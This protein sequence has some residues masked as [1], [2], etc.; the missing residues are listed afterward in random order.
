MTKECYQ[1]KVSRSFRISKRYNKFKALAILTMGVAGSLCNVNSSHAV[2]S[3]KEIDV[4]VV[5][6]NSDPITYG[7]PT[8]VPGSEVSMIVKLTKSG[9][10]NIFTNE[11]SGTIV[12]NYAASG[13]QQVDLFGISSF[14][15]TAPYTYNSQDIIITNKA[16]IDLTATGT[17]MLTGHNSN[18]TANVAGIYGTVDTN[19]GEIDVTASGGYFGPISPIVASGSANAFAKGIYGN[20]EKNSG[21]ITASAT[22]GYVRAVGIAEAYST[23]RGIYG[24]V[25]VNEGNIQ[26]FAKG[27]TAT[28]TASNTGAFSSAN[29][30]GILGKVVRNTGNINVIVEGGVARTPAG[31]RSA[32]VSNAFAYGVK[33]SVGE[34][35]GAIVVSAQGGSS[36]ITESGPT[37]IIAK[38][39]S[40]GLHN[41]TIRTDALTNSGLINVTATG[42]KIST[43][44]GGSWRGDSAKSYGIYDSGNIVNSKTGYIKTIAQ[45]ALELTDDRVDAEIKSYGVYFHD[46]GILDSA[47]LIDAE[48]RDPFGNRIS[49]NNFTSDIHAYQVYAASGATTI[50]GFAMD[51]QG[52]QAELNTK[53]EGAISA[54]SGATVQFG[55]NAK[56]YVYVN[57]E[58][59]V[60]GNTYTIPILIDGD[61]P[62]GYFSTAEEV[63]INPDYRL[64]EMSEKSDTALQT[65]TFEYSPQASTPLFSAQGINTMTQQSRAIVNAATSNTIIRSM[66]KNDPRLA[67]YDGVA[68]ASNDQLTD[69]NAV[70]EA[71]RVE[72]KGT[73]FFQP[74]YVNSSYDSSPM[75]Y[76]ADVYGFVGGY[77]YQPNKNMVLGFHAGYG[78]V[79]MDYNGDGY[80]RRSEKIDAGSVG[81][82]GALNFNDN[83]L[84]KGTSTL[85]FTSNDYEDRVDT[86]R[87]TGDYDT[88]NIRTGIDLGYI[89]MVGNGYIIPEIGLSHLY[90]SADS[91][92]TNNLNNNDVTYSDVS[93]NEIYA[94]LGMG[95]YGNYESGQWDITPRVK[96]GI[97]QTLTDGEYANSMTSGGLSRSVSYD[98]DKTA[99]ITDLGLEFGK[100]PVVLGAGYSGYYSSDIDDHSLYLELRYV[101]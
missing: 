40:Y 41:T 52:T 60:E 81:V 94:H 98:A 17:V 45:Q 57:G 90:Y 87:E 63:N 85:T 16:K 55:N 7:V 48:V 101:F 19:E 67:A 26:V 49:R 43:N 14:V 58:I 54:A 97:E 80:D 4:S 27:G 96:V 75:G 78:N 12:S 77:N 84:L 69:V 3:A 74:Y 59:K 31:I 72:E 1:A 21:D 64:V 39:E 100:G 66:F 30:R 8:L 25:A 92:T 88:W 9:A 28:T 13:I 20:V 34:N 99:V 6:S 24:D 35:T 11:Q 32:T 10:D 91:F 23:A 29:A 73:V 86:N 53:Y 65:I 70:L 33:G 71:N 15:E 44:G 62:K 50:N 93:E 68:L 38:A 46:T 42:G 82:Q 18:V 95:W 47:G 36:S 83:W 2:Y 22:A 61:T 5:N 89:F 79:D 76:D 37:A 56:L 51:F